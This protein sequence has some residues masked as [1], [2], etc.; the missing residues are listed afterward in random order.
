MSA[1]IFFEKNEYYPGETTTAKIICDNSQCDKDIIAFELTLSF[2]SKGDDSCDWSTER[3]ELL[4]VNTL[5]GMARG[6]Q[7]EREFVINIPSKC[8][9]P[10]W[11]KK[12]CPLDDK[13]LLGNFIPSFK[14]K[15]ITIEYELKL[16]LIH[17][18]CCCSV[19]AISLPIQIM[20]PPT[21]R[22]ET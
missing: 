19:E 4:D 9:F 16:S 10:D 8:D 20:I 17:D 22:Y 11:Q 2:R 15:L 12:L 7:G 13:P 1:K 18:G 6:E 3:T 21:Q 5:E 14:G